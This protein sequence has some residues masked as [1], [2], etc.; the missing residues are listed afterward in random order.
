M[1]IQDCFHLKILKFIFFSVRNVKKYICV[2]F[3]TFFKKHSTL[4]HLE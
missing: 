4:V 2:E 1:I 3:L